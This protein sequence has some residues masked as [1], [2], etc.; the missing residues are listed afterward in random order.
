M[1]N[2]NEINITISGSVCSGKTSVARL[3]K[4]VL[5]TNAG[6]ES[7]IDDIDHPDDIGDLHD[8]RDRLN[9][10]SDKGTSVNIKTIQTPRRKP[11]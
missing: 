2:P 1:T 4:F 11:I 7:T 9:S 3:L 8:L 10:I 5:Q 6:I